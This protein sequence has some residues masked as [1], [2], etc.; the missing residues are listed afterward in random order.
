V[1]F[2]RS[3]SGSNLGSVLPRKEWLHLLTGGSRMKLK[4]LYF[5]KDSERFAD[6]M[7]ICARRRKDKPT[8]EV[9]MHA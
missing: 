9:V 8:G 2:R 6:A 4:S 7:H 3:F 5:M 1:Y